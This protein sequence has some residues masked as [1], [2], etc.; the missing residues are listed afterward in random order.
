MITYLRRSHVLT[1]AQNGEGK[2]RDGTQCKL[3]AVWLVPWQCV[4]FSFKWLPHKVIEMWPWSGPHPSAP[5]TL[6]SS[7]LTVLS[8]S[9][10]RLAS[11]Q[12]AATCLSWQHLKELTTGRDYSAVSAHSKRSA[13]RFLLLSSSSSSLSSSLGA[14]LSS[15][16]SFSLVFCRLVS[17]FSKV[18][19]KWPHFDIFLWLE[20]GLQLRLGLQPQLGPGL[21]ATGHDSTR[22]WVI[23]VDIV[24][25]KYLM[26]TKNIHIK[27]RK[28]RSN[29]QPHWC[30]HL[31]VS[32]TLY[33]SLPHLH[34]S[35]SLSLSVSDCL[36]VFIAI[37][38]ISIKFFY[39]N[40][41]TLS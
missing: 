8:Y 36:T 35:L 28:S 33:T 10:P 29:L 19:P 3:P 30:L 41:K 23:H 6:P 24:C 7:S 27:S 11:S 1:C 39:D 38:G 26:P 37:F 22:E 31:A 13:T 40:I 18:A 15:P 21:L 20:D 14:A 17:W 32:L 2:E 25:N 5:L 16:S 34:P 12:F 9:S 4:A